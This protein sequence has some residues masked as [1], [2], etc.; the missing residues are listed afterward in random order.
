M[1]E[2]AKIVGVILGAAAVLFKFFNLTKQID[3]LRKE[4]RDLKEDVDVELDQKQPRELC[5]QIHKTTDDRLE[6]QNKLWK[7]VNAEITAIKVHMAAIAAK[8]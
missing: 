5:Q 3:E 2:T 6:E 1:I 4:M 8:I 7:S